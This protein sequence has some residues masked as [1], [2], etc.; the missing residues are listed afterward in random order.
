MGALESLTSES[1][2][3]PFGDATEEEVTQH[4]INV[5]DQIGYGGCI[6]NF[7]DTNVLILGN[8]GGN[9]AW[10]SGM[11]WMFDSE[12]IFQLQNAREVMFEVLVYTT[13]E[14][15]RVKV[16]SGDLGK[17]A[18]NFRIPSANRF[19]NERFIMP[20]DE[21][22]KIELLMESASTVWVEIRL[23]GWL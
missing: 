1:N 13:T 22:V 7:I 17:V 5:I 23:L 6:M 21:Y 3:E 15:G 16:S 8:T 12:T 11:N 9:V 2:W 10:Y 18:Q 20:L 4:F 19:Y 14:N